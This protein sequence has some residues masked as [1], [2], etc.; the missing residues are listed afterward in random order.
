M[1]ISVDSRLSKKMLIERIFAFERENMGKVYSNSEDVPLVENSI[2]LSEGEFSEYLDLLIEGI[3]KLF[4]WELIDFLIS[5]P[6]IFNKKMMET[7]SLSNLKIDET[8]RNFSKKGIKEKI[9]REKIIFEISRFSLFLKVI[10]LFFIAMLS[11]FYAFFAEIKNDTNF[12][13]AFFPMFSVWFVI[14]SIKTRLCITRKEIYKQPSLFGIPILP[15]TS[16]QNIDVGDIKIMKENHYKLVFYKKGG[17]QV[18]LSLLVPS[19]ESAQ[20]IIYKIVEFS[21]NNLQVGGR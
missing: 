13:E 4:G 3:I 16:I 21:K 10:L 6:E 14:L 18:L 2:L 9:K 8:I 15:K 5:P 19:K 1:V 7:N 11:G 20:Y 17:K 12:W